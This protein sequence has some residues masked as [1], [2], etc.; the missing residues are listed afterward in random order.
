VELREG[1]GK[2]NFVRRD[3]DSLLSGIWTPVTNTY[4]ITQVTNSAPLVQTYQ[5]IVTQPDILITASDLTAGPAGVLVNPF[6]ARGINFN[7]TQVPTNLAGPGTI[8]PAVSF[9][10]NKVGPVY[11]AQSPG[12]L[13]DG[14]AGFTFIW[15]SF[16]GT[17][18]DPVVY[19]ST[20]SLSNLLS[21]IFFQITTNSPPQASISTNNAGNPY[22]FQL[23]ATGGTPPYTWS[24][25]TNSPAL[26][27]GLG[28]SATGDISGV[29]TAT[30]I[31]DFIVEVTDSSVLSLTNQRN[32]SIQVVP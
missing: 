2:I 22:N 21:D 11:D 29:P 5:R 26:P 28:L 19:P 20:V 4:Q 13:T 18:N 12:F 15:G 8:Q 23:S 7:S 9:T 3:F 24:L 1:V 14:T 17:T 25:P 32:F 27:P 31:Y 10:Y 6:A 30:G 16:D